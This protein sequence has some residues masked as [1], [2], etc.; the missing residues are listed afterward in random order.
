MWLLLSLVRDFFDSIQYFSIEPRRLLY[1]LGLAIVGGLCALA[2]AR[3]SFDAQ[4]RVQLCA[5]GAAASALTLCIVYMVVRLVPLF[6]LVMESGAI[7]GVLLVFLLLAVTA[8]Y[9]WLEFSRALKGENS[10]GK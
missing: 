3:F 9:L 4:R 1:V 10:P 2:L 5:W 7:L 6:S 8:A